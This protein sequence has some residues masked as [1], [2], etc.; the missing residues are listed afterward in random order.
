MT[1]RASK[2]DKQIVSVNPPTPAEYGGMN[3]AA[4]P[5][6]RRR[7]QMLKGRWETISLCFHP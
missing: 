7:F 2:D 1:F 4:G 5:S 3:Y 6:I